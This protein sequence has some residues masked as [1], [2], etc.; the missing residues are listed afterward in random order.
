MNAN[1]KDKNWLNA[2]IWDDTDEHGMELCT[3]DIPIK[4][5]YTDPALVFPLQSKKAIHFRT[6]AEK[7][8]A[9]NKPGLHRSSMMRYSSI[10]RTVDIQ[11]MMLRNK[12]QY[13]L[14]K[15]FPPSEMRH[16]RKYR[17]PKL[18]IPNNPISHSEAAKKHPKFGTEPTSY[19]VRSFTPLHLLS[20]KK[21]PW[22]RLKFGQP[23]SLP[24]EIN[25][26]ITDHK[27]LFAS[28]KDKGEM[29]LFEYLE[30]KPPLLNSGMG[31]KITIITWEKGAMVQVEIKRT[32]IQKN[33]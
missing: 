13:L 25:H 6:Y 15:S 7:Q 1:L 29:V 30:E 16:R 33:S 28:S 20:K 32:A 2:V 23:F 8:W 11:E 21:E 12:I 4:L 26:S 10:D 19:S 22:V 31:A 5:D 24:M 9:K 17:D 27:S 18:K 3:R 14:T